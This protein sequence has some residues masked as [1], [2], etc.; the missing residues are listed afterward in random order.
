MT[1]AG[2][3]PIAEFEYPDDHSNRT[4]PPSSCASTITGKYIPPA[5]P[6]PP[7]LSNH[8][9]PPEQP[10]CQIKHIFIPEMSAKAVDQWLFTEAELKATPSILDGLS[11]EEERIRRAKGVSFMSSIGNMLH[12]PMTTVSVASLYFHRFYMR[13]SMV[14]DKKGCTGIHHYVSFF[15][16]PRVIT[17]SPRLYLCARGALVLNL[18][19]H[20]YTIRLPEQ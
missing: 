10:F 20:S 13:K 2:P 16:L 3:Y 17:S 6:S 9:L 15:L 14:S 5:V 11:H 19:F 7:R 18:T 1:T 12:I 8:H 4:R